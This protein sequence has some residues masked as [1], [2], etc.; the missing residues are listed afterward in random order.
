MLF[1]LGASL[2]GVFG[3]ALPLPLGEWTVE[4]LTSDGRIFCALA[5]RKG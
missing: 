4:K 1:Q 5:A 2:D 3:V